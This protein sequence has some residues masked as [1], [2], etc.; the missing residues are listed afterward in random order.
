MEILS[1]FDTTHS[2]NEVNLHNLFQEDASSG[3]TSIIKLRTNLFCFLDL[4]R[5]RVFFVANNPVALHKLKLL[6]GEFSNGD[7]GVLLSTKIILQ[8]KRFHE[9]FSSIFAYYRQKN[10]VVALANPDDKSFEPSNQ[11]QEAK[12]Q[13]NNRQ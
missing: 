11:T 13:V 5:I 1:L 10:Q 6:M 4:S 2:S 3:A 12:Q 8:F 7:V 9:H